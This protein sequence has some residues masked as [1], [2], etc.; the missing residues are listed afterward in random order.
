M[1]IFHFGGLSLWLVTYL[2]YHRSITWVAKRGDAL[3]LEVFKLSLSYLEE[4]EALRCDYLELI[5]FDQKGLPL[6]QM[7]TEDT[8]SSS[9]GSIV[10]YTIF[11]GT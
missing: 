4:I 1:R 11:F 8:D 10:Y 9:L 6:N 5:G 7:Q 3:A 2:V